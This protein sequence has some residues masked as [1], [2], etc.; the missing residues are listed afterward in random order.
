MRISNIKCAPEKLTKNLNDVYSIIWEPSQCYL[1]VT[2][3]YNILLFFMRYRSWINMFLIKIITMLVEICEFCCFS[4]RMCIVFKI[5]IKSY[6]DTHE[7]SK[8]CKNFGYGISPSLS[9]PTSVLSCSHWRSD[10]GYPSRFSIP[11]L[12]SCGVITPRQYLSQDLN[13]ENKKS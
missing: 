9:C 8:S 2:W 4:K 5:Y 12:N 13:E 7:T 1:E 11:L 3:S 6:I 10:I